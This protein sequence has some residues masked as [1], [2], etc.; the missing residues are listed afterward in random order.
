MDDLHRFY[1]FGDPK[2]ILKELHENAKYGGLIEMRG[3]NPMAYMLGHILRKLDDKTLEDQH[4]EHVQYYPAW[5]T[6]PAYW[7]ANTKGTR[8]LLDE[9]SQSPNAQVRTKSRIC[10]RRKPPVELTDTTWNPIQTVSNAKTMRDQHALELWTSW[11][12]IGEEALLDSMVRF[13]GKTKLQELRQHFV[14]LPSLKTFN[15]A[16]QALGKPESLEDETYM[17]QV[18][19]V[20]AKTFISFMGEHGQKVKGL[21][22]DVRNTDNDWN[23]LVGFCARWLSTRDMTK[24]VERLRK[25]GLERAQ[26][27]FLTSY[28][29][30]DIYKLQ[31]D[32]RLGVQKTEQDNTDLI[33]EEVNKAGRR[34]RADERL[35]ELKIE[36][37]RLAKQFK[38]MGIEDTRM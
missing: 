18:R 9:A 32:K 2:H 34:K 11:Y 4:E 8:K 5:L 17:G 13:V 29:L 21:L 7:Y 14:D 22:R 19:N 30:D 1:K 23:M 15:D 12:M 20:V 25:Q 27:L 28:V 6:A 33:Y 31:M 37:K 24:T 26:E 36:K 10:L 38:A 35:V 16:I 3:E